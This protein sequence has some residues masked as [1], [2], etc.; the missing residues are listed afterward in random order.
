MSQVSAESTPRVTPPAIE[1]LDVTV[2]SSHDST[3]RLEGVNW[4]IECRDFWVVGGL[5]GSGK[6][7]L[8]AT[9]A[10]LMRPAQGSHRIFGRDVSELSQDQTIEERLR[11]GV[12]FGEE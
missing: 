9:A 7:D 11:I 8:L 3:P 4:K 10:G 12:V 1:L 2:Q 5:P 6:S